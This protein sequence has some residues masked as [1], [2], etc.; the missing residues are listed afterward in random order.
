[1]TWLMLS[2]APRATMRWDMCVKGNLRQKNQSFKKELW[3]VLKTM[4]GDQQE[5]FACHD[6][7]R[8]GEPPKGEFGRNM[9]GWRVVWGEK[10]VKAI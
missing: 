4:N 7:R 2:K 1:M 6:R 3:T 8:S 9:G 5:S 10:K